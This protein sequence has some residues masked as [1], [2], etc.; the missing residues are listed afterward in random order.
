MAAET[1]L[2]ELLARER[3]ALDSWSPRDT[4]GYAAMLDD[5]ATYFDHATR[6]R[7]AGRPA[8]DAHVRAFEGKFSF[9]RYEIVEPILHQSGD[10][11]VLAFNWDPY[12]PDDQLIVR[13]NATSVYRRVDGRWRIVHAHWSMAPKA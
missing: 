3:E 4:P 10:V 7:L 13:W 5:H 11:A 8:V 1:L 6:A 9:P 2:N 12:G